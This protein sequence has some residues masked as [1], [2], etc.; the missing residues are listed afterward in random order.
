M[1]KKIILVMLLL[2][3]VSCSEVSVS[4]QSD[5]GG[6]KWMAYCSLPLYEIELVDE[7]IPINCY[8]W[9]TQKLYDFEYDRINKSFQYTGISLYQVWREQNPNTNCELLRPL[10]YDLPLYCLRDKSA[11][12]EVENDKICR[13][14]NLSN[15]R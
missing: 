11:C 2:F 8:A 6:K 15:W 4:S 12:L 3:L 10:N 14:I 1:V 7:L 5:E 13:L 9:K